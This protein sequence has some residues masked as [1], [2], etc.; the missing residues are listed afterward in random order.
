VTNLKLPPLTYDSLNARLKGAP[1]R[2]IG[3]AT[4]V[5]RDY[6]YEG[7]ISIVHHGSVIADVSQGEVFLRKVEYHSQTTAY[8]LNRVCADNGLE[9]RVGLRKGWTCMLLQSAGKQV[10]YQI[11]N[12][13]TL[14]IGVD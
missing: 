9:T 13:C 1:S 5:E 6:R 3:Y 10:E 11:K 7:V 8:R 14:L 2:K 4:W 12:D